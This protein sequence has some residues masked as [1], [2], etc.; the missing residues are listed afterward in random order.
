MGGP[1]P[2]GEEQVMGEYHGTSAD[3]EITPDFVSPSVDVVS[4]PKEPSDERD[5]LFGGGGGGEDTLV[6]CQSSFD[7]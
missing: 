5:T 3:E 6:L 1:V 2:G 7:G 4:G